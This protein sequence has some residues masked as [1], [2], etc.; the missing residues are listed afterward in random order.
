MR[1]KRALIVVA[2]EPSPG[3]TKTRLVPPLT[4]EEAAE[5]YRC[6]LSDTLELMGRVDG[7]QPV[8]AYTPAQAEP[9]FRGFVPHGFQLIA[10]RGPTLGQR[11]DNVLR[12]HLEQGYVQAVVMDSDSPTLPPAYLQQAFQQLDQPEVD[13]VLGPTEDGGYYLIGLK[14]P[15]SALFEVAMSTPTVLQ[16]TLELARRQGLRVACLPAWY[17]VDNAEDLQRLRREL[18]AQP[19]DIAPSTRRLLVTWSD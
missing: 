19:N 2:K 9:F 16:E 7:A 6:L 3:T 18:A 4:P 11:L 1:M 14:R 17:D 5:L 13:V 15:C 12:A 8:L 10:Q